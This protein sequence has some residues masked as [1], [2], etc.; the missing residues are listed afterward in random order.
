MLDY[1]AFGLLLVVFLIDP[2]MFSFVLLD[3][4]AL[5]CFIEGYFLLVLSAE[6]RLYF[7]SCLAAGFGVGAIFLMGLAL[8]NFSTTLAV[9]IYLF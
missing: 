9:F 5:S 7:F 4:A 6:R 8:G 1:F 2:L 3:L